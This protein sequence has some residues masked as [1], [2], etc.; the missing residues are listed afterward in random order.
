M[1]LSRWHRALATGLQTA[2][3]ALV[4]RVCR[5]PVIAAAGLGAGAAALSYA[6]G[7]VIGVSLA[8]IAGATMHLL[9][10]T[11]AVAASASALE[12]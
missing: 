1:P 10:L 2:A 4:R 11:E 5:Y 7:P 8:G 3:W 9:G 6:A 12:R